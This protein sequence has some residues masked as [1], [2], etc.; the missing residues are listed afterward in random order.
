MF[1]DLWD[2]VSA[3][4]VPVMLARGMLPQSVIRDADEAELLRR[5]PDAKVVHFDRAG[6]SI[7]GDMPVELADAIATFVFS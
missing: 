2:V 1:T 7:Q 5:Q 3:I 4:R 6:H